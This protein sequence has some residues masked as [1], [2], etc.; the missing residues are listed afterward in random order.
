MS[1]K[2]SRHRENQLIESFNV[3]FICV[4]II[5]ITSVAL[6]ETRFR[7][8]KNKSKQKKKKKMIWKVD[9]ERKRYNVLPS[10]RKNSVS[11]DETAFNRGPT[12]LTT[13]GGTFREAHVKRAHWFYPNGIFMDASTR[14]AT[15]RNRCV[16]CRRNGT[17]RG[18]IEGW[19]ISWYIWRVKLRNR[20]IISINNFDR[21]FL[22]LND[23]VVKLR[24]LMINLGVYANL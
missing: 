21:C 14:D 9:I 18:S 24:Y 17:G 10:G 2:S 23:F 6:K 19:T 4:Y 8:G 20:D 22:E 13:L 11:S 3:W 1:D 7:G 5:R 12:R 15:R 16:A